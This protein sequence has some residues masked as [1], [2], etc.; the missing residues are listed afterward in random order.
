[1]GRKNHHKRGRP[2]DADLIEEILQEKPS[3]PLAGQL[4][5]SESL[6]EPSAADLAYRHAVAACDRIIAE[7][8]EEL[9]GY[10]ENSNRPSDS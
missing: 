2:L 1:M 9:N 7:L 3:Q 10:A 6:C 5:Q 8:E 4:S